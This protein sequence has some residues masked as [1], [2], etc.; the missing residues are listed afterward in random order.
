MSRYRPILGDLH[1][2]CRPNVE[3]TL[4]LAGNLV[5]LKLL[6]ILQSTIRKDREEARFPVLHDLA[7]I[8]TWLISMA[9]K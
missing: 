9:L 5:I 1:L 3:L 2:A 6:V 7:H 8:E 4:L